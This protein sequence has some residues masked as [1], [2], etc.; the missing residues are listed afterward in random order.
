MTGPADSSIRAIQHWTAEAL[1]LPAHAVLRC[2]QPLEDG[3]IVVGSDFGLTCVEGSLAHPISFPKGSRR[4]ARDV[5]SMAL[6]GGHLHVA[7]ARGVYLWKE[8]ILEGRG[9]PPD[10]AGGFDDLFAVHDHHGRLIRAW[11]THLEGGEGPPGVQ[12]LSSTPEGELY[13]GTTDG[14]LVHV[15]HGTIQRFELEG[16][17]APVRHLEWCQ[18]ALWIAAAGALHRWDQQ[19]WSSQDGEPVALC[20]DSQDRLWLL[21]AEQ[22]H[23]IEAGERRLA[24]SDLRRPW[25]LAATDSTLWVG[26]RGGLYGLSFSEIG[27]QTR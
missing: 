8:D 3:S 5:L 10:G 25:C 19:A 23:V 9:L 13:A 18:E 1:G 6:L 2:I 26:A 12:C 17:S 4:E 21:A 27:S 7:T 24:V 14:Q 15:N 11:R 22:L 20:A 16:H